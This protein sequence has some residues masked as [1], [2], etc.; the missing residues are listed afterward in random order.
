M[1]FITGEDGRIQRVVFSDGRQFIY[2]Y[3]AA[4][5]LN[6]VRNLEQALSQNYGYGEGGSH[7]LV[8]ATPGWVA[9]V[10]R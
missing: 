4:G 9:A 10:A 1:S 3:D 6:L 2:G 8:L 5:N 7:S